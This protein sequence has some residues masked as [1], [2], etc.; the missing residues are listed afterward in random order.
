MKIAEH[1]N[2]NIL[3]KKN[4]HNYNVVIFSRYYDNIH[5]NINAYITLLSVLTLKT[6]LIINAIRI[7][8][9]TIL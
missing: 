6:I 1:N 2:D 4:V 7:G 8:T 5:N 9:A 3:G